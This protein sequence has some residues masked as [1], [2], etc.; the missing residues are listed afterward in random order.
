MLLIVSLEWVL[1]GK[2]PFADKALDMFPAS[3]D[4]C[5]KCS[6]NTYLDEF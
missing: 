2:F 5:E 6:L 3:V 1:V 4:Q